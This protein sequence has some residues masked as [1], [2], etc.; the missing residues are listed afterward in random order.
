MSAM[1]R[2]LNQHCET[3]TSMTSAS[4]TTSA[5]LST[6]RR[7]KGMPQADKEDAST[8]AYPDYEAKLNHQICGGC[9]SHLHGTPGT[10]SRQLKCPWGQAYS[11]CR[12]PN[13]LL[14]VCQ[15]KKV[16]QVVRKG[17]EANEATMDTLITH[18]TFNQTMDIYMAK[19]N[20]GDRGICHAILSKA[21]SQAS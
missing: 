13:H 19:P 2:H 16:A 12:K 10:K 1:L 17:P 6:Y 15:A 20:N 21:R 3:K 9:G 7:Q 18:I 5:W 8:N 14:K 11:N 4:D